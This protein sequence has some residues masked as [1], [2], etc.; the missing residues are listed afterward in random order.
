MKTPTRIFNYLFVIGILGLS[1]MFAKNLA[2]KKKPPD[3][4]PTAIFRKEVKVKPVKN[5]EIESEIEVNGKLIPRDKVE[6]FAEVSGNLIA[7]RKPFKAGTRYA[8][9]E[10]LVL[11]DN[12]Q[13]ILN[14]QSAKSKLLNL[15]T[16]ALPDLQFDYPE[17][18]PAWKAYLD[19]FDIKAPL[20]PLPNARDEQEKFYIS[21]RSIYD[22]WYSIRSSEVLLEKYRIVAPYSG[23][24]TEAFVH[25][26]MLVRPNMKLGEF[27]STGAFE[28]AANISVPELD[29]VHVG[30]KVTLRS[31][32]LQGEWEGVIVRI[33]DRIDQRT[34]TVTVYVGVSGNNLKEGM[35][36]SGTVTTRT[37][38]NATTISRDL[39]QNRNAVYVCRDSTLKLI[40]VTPIHYSGEEVV[41]TGI[42]DG[43]KL[44]VEPLPGA[45]EGMTVSPISDK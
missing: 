15:I 6:I 3:T 2:S 16:L 37:I 34:Q 13:T 40:P 12:E 31:E 42:Q 26:G 10:T 27:I 29:F 4:K 8:A 17:S 25:P 35:Y 21:G 19:S 36:L 24:V 11:I 14:I 18:Y 43:E 41:V 20:L 22:T 5:S 39:L 7:T 33:N 30:G 32:D 28:L 38:K 9:G 44:V 1:F 45:A 23:V